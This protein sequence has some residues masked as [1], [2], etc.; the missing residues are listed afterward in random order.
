[1]E[2]PQEQIAPPSLD[3]RIEVITDSAL[4]LIQE[5][6]QSSAWRDTLGYFDGDGG[7][8]NYTVDEASRLHVSLVFGAGYGGGYSDSTSVTVSSNEYDAVT[9]ESF[10]AWPSTRGQRVKSNEAKVTDPQELENTVTYAELAMEIFYT[11]IARNAVCTLR[12]RKAENAK[13]LQELR[14]ATKM[15]ELEVDEATYFRYTQ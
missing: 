1:M 8:I 3:E 12:E 11:D 13:P 6:G 9:L 4:Q 10:F 14:Y 15:T 2:Q 5:Q 7:R